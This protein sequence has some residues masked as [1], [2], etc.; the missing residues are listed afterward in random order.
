MCR[1]PKASPRLSKHR[2]PQL[3]LEV[4]TRMI[5]TSLSCCKGLQGLKGPGCFVYSAN[6]PGGF[7]AG[8]SASAS[9]RWETHF[10]LCPRPS[11][12]AFF[13]VVNLTGPHPSCNQEARQCSYFP[14]ANQCS[15][16][17]D[18]HS[19]DVKHRAGS[20]YFCFSAPLL[21]SREETHLSPVS[22]PG[23]PMCSQKCMR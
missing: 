12:G 17:C 5:L 15:L 22:H 7:P 3:Q 19:R 11:L 13:S 18:V 16:E 6:Y 10:Q 8:P 14:G 2:D 1:R 9:T 23:P 4:Q 20:S 21:P